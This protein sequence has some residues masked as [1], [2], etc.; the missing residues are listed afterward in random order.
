V[1]LQFVNRAI[2]IIIIIIITI[3]ATDVRILRELINYECGVRK[4]VYTLDDVR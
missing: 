2:I 4:F 1:H 3:K